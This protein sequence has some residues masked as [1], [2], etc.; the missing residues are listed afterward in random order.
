MTKKIVSILIAAVIVAL[1]F[2]ACTF[3]SEPLFG[4]VLITGPEGEIILDS[5]VFVS[6]K[7]ATVADAIIEGCSEFRIPFTFEN[8]MFDNFDGI[9]STMDDGWLLYYEGELSDAGASS[10]ELSDNFDIEFKFVNY[11]ESFTLE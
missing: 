11:D 3:K 7:N 4:V 6:K 2:S 8:G 9:P 1:C 5:E 10:I